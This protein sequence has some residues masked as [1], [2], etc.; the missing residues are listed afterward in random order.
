M[1]QEIVQDNKYIEECDNLYVKLRIGYG[2]K[3]IER[4]DFNDICHNVIR[5]SLPF[6]Y[7]IDAAVVEEAKQLSTFMGR[8]RFLFKAK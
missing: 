7:S 8:L 1:L 4:E 2:D 5:I 3:M 6:I